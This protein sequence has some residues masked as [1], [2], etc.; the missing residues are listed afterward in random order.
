MKNKSFTPIVLILIIIGIFVVGGI[1]Y[2]YYQKQKQIQEQSNQQLQELGQQTDEAIRQKHRDAKRISDI[3]DIRS[4]LE[5]YYNIYKVY[6]DN[7][8]VFINPENS[9]L[10]EFSYMPSNPTPGGIDY[11]YKSINNG[12]TYTLKYALEAKIGKFNAGEQVATPKNVGS[13]IDQD[14]QSESG[15]QMEQ[16]N[17]E[18]SNATEFQLR[19]K[20]RVSDIKQIQLALIMFH[21]QY[22]GYPDNLSDLIS[23]HFIGAIPTNPIPGGIDYKYQV[24]SSGSNYLL[25][26]SLEVGYSDNVESFSAGKHA[27]SQEGIQ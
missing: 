1:V 16:E 24:L 20:K 8:E 4:A 19:D 9:N 6:P 18:T 12:E 21:D 5:N 27:A 22:N 7:L 11:E 23:S 14:F 25:E 2:S 13:N 3:Q 15:N 17:N 26:F 10:K